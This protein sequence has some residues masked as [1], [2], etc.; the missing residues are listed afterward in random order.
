MI[1][2]V[3]ILLL[4]MQNNLLRYLLKINK[5]NY[6]SSIQQALKIFSF[7]H[8]YYKYKLGFTVQVESYVL[9]KQ[10]FDYIETQD[11]KLKK[12]SLSYAKSLNQLANQLIS[13][14]KNDRGI[15]KKLN[16]QL[17]VLNEKFNKNQKW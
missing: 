8:L 6:L 2:C 1:S 7:K 4:L 10:I 12:L 11:N 3:Q 15:R 9:S 13:V 14:D 16:D 5:H 17:V